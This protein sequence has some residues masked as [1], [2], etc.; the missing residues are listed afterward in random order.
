MNTEI[1]VMIKSVYGKATIYPVCET[2][3]SLAALAGTK[4]LTDSN[5][6]LIKSIGYTII[7]QPEFAT[8]L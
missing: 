5:I 7:A 4:T 1:K 3:K 8:E 2:A 6:K